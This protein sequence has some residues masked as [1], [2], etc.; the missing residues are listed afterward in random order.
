MNVS[1]IAKK[2][3]PVIASTLAVGS[4]AFQAGRESNR[5]DELFKKAHAAESERKAIN[6]VLYDIH[7]KV[8]GIEKDIQYMKK[9]I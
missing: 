1:D 6:E 9:K 3:S 2:I 7:G 4:L 5:I 8:C